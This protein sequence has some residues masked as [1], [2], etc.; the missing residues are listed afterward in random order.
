MRNRIGDVLCVDIR[1]L[2]DI[3]RAADREAACIASGIET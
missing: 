2:R 3:V 1:L